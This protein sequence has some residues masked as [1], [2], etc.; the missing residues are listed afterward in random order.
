M[1]DNYVES[2]RTCSKLRVV[3]GPLQIHRLLLRNVTGLDG[4]MYIKMSSVHLFD[5]QFRMF[6]QPYNGG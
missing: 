2:C 6:D 3:T 4:G 5:H 1:G